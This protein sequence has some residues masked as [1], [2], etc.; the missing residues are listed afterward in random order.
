M[1]A[2]RFTLKFRTKNAF[3]SVDSDLTTH[4]MILDSISRRFVVV[5]NLQNSFPAGSFPGQNWLYFF[6]FFSTALFFPLNFTGRSTSLHFVNR[7]CIGH[8]GG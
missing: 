5:L 3:R 4:S 8:R 1:A 6:S 2:T 7:P